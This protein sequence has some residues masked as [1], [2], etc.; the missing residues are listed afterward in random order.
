MLLHLQAVPLRIG[1]VHS[2]TFASVEQLSAS[3]NI[4]GRSPG[5]AGN[6]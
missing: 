1:P 5:I 2:T 6:S 3:I 4:S